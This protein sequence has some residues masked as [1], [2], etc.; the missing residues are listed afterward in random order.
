MEGVKAGSLRLGE[1]TKLYEYVKPGEDT[2]P[3]FVSKAIGFWKSHV[4]EG[5]N[6]KELKKAERSEIPPHVLARHSTKAGDIITY[7]LNEDECRFIDD[8][9][10]EYQDE[11]MMLKYPQFPW[12]LRCIIR[13]YCFF[14]LEDKSEDEIFRKEPNKPNW[15]KM[16]HE[17]FPGMS[18]EAIE[19]ELRKL[20]A[21]EQ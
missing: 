16:M 2:H 19:D 18:D 11:C 6:V 10:Q 13:Y 5:V 7:K 4:D 17:L 15:E 21:K 8:Q 20:V 9:R 3:M 12:F 14:L 1:L